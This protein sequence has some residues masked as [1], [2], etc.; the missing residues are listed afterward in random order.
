M[1]LPASVQ[2]FGFV[3]LILGNFTYNEVIEWP[4]EFL[5]KDLVKYRNAKKVDEN[6]EDFV[7]YAKED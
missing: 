1:L 5:R 3:F 2:L 6:S 7:D 4:V